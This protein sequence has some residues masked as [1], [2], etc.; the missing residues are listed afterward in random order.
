MQTAGSALASIPKPIG[1]LT[2]TATNIPAQQNAVG[3]GGE[4]QMAFPHLALA[5]GRTP[6]GFL[7]ANYTGR[8]YWKPANGPFTFNFSRDSVR[9]T[10]L[11]YAGLRDPGGSSLGNLGQIWGGV[12]ANQGQVQFAHGDAQSGYY[13]NAGGQ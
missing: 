4:V 9:D 8:V 2:T 1:T 7:V 13:F 3:V 10:Q 11:S 5:A 12:V 6:S